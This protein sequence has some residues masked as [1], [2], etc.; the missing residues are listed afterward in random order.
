LKNI[1]Y[2]EAG[3]DVA[4][5]GCFRVI[6][7]PEGIKRRERYIDAEMNYKPR[8]NSKTKRVNIP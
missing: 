3:T 4:G 8:F 6:P 2:G 7:W 5:A 1:L